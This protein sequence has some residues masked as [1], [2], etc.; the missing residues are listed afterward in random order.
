M[1]GKV[2]EIEMRQLVRIAIES[3]QEE[4]LLQVR[5]EGLSAAEKEKWFVDSG[6]NRT[7]TTKDSAYSL[8]V[9]HHQGKYPVLQGSYS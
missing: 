3:T 1:S 7:L 6:F 2:S 9:I 5:M 4:P 8:Y